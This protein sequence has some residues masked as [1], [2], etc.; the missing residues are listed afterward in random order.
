MN[1]IHLTKAFSLTVVILAL[2][3]CSSLPFMRNSSGTAT[4]Q[5]VRDIPYC[6]VN[7]T[8]LCLIS[9]GTDQKGQMF[10]NFYRPNLSIK[11][12]Y[13]KI[14]YDQLENMYECEAVKGFTKYISCTGM[15][16]PLEEQIDLGVYLS[17]DNTLIARGVFVISFFAI[18]TP[19]LV[20][21]FEGTIGPTSAL[22]TPIP[23]QTQ[24]PQVTGTSGT[25][26]LTPRAG[27]T[28]TTTRTPTRTPTRSYP[29]P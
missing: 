20:T 17:A 19:I 8:V 1:R 25:P 6:D 16:I 24:T 23:T 21:T 12:F 13:L 11:D 29:N 9:F 28:G 5:A 2:V 10:V 26:T 22:T 3:A 27:P 4:S 14:Q 18:A 7:S 15:Q